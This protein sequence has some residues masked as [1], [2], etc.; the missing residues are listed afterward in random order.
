MDDKRS[1]EVVYSPRLFSN[2]TTKKPYVVVVTDVFRATT[3]I[4]AALD[5]GVK[6]IIPVKRIRH[7][8]FL[9]RLGF[10]VAAE[11]GGNKVKFADLDNSALSFFNERFKGK[12]IV[13]STTNGTKAIRLASSEAARIAVGAFVN[14]KALSQWIVRQ[15]KNVVILCAGWKNKVNMEDSLFA[16]A[17]S[18]LLLESGKFDTDC[19]A[20]K[21]AM[22]QWELAKDD[23]QGYIARS[24][25]RNR[26]R[27]LV[28]DEVLDYTFNI[29]SSQVVPVLKGYK[30]VP[31]QD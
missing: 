16:G 9:K 2:I 19:D 21:M 31:A 20:A 28:S 23:I 30:I 14:I 8:R 15:D 13:Y 27:H 10:L 1:I 22:D 17:L 26:L 18:E 4:C 25:H 5:Y 12:E 7:A 3:S 24:S 6:A 29:D 11:R